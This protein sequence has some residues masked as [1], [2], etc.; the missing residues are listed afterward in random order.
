[1]FRDKIKEKHDELT[2]SFQKLA[3]FI[4]DNELDAAFMTATELAERLQ[5]DAAT[6]VRFAQQLGY[7]GFRE[8]SKEIQ[9]VVRADLKA[10]YTAN[11]DAPADVGL[12][13]GLLANER[14]NLK[15][16]QDRLTEEA[17]LLLP[18]LLNADR[19]WIVGQG[20][21]AHLASL[22]AEALRE[23]ELPAI[24]VAPDPLSAA[25]NLKEVGADDLVIGFSITGM[26]LDTANVISFARRRGAA[27]FGLSASPI[28][29][30]ALEAE[31]GIICP[32]PT[33]THV[34]SFTGLAAIIVAVVAAFT[35]RYPEEA[36]AIKNAVRDSYRD[37]LDGQEKRSAELD[38]ETLWRQL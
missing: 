13:R 3:D 31:T 30:T 15:L 26:D 36:M 5:V 6:V 24:A 2:P 11:L 12:L 17:N 27:T 21:C 34:S 1:M 14:Q 22:C 20:R 33:Q 23:V 18:A 32:G 19:I 25:A 4:Q 10:E 8:L 38:V 9:E 28:A 37:L 29:A 35:V 7:S 16:A